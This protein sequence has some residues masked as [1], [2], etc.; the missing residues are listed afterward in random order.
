MTFWLKIL[1]VSINPAWTL[2][3]KNINYYTGSK[4]WV[5]EVTAIDGSTI[6]YARTIRHGKFTREWRKEVSDGNA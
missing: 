5:T 6:G 2:K 4:D 1:I 3:E